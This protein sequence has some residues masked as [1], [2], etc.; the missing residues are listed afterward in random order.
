MGAQVACKYCVRKFLMGTILSLWTSS[1]I[2][3]N[4][5]KLVNPQPSTSFLLQ[6][7]TIGL[8]SPSSSLIGDR[9]WSFSLSQGSGLETLLRQVGTHFLPTLVRWGIFVQRVCYFSLLV[10]LLL[11]YPSNFICFFFFFSPPGVRRPSLSKFYLDHVQQASSFTNKAFHS[12]VTYVVQLLGGLD[13]NQL[14]R[15]LLRAHHTQT[16]VIYIVS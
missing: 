12:L 13:L 2:V 4:P 5:R 15:H 6:V 1:Y 14:R 10:L 16:C 3:T 8:S 7:Q 9:R 11:L